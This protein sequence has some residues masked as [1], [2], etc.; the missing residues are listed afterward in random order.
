MVKGAAGAGFEGRF[1]FGFGFGAAAGFLASLTS[2]P[3]PQLE[4]PVNATSDKTN[5]VK[6][7]RA[8]VT[9]WRH[10]GAGVT[11]ED[12]LRFFI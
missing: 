5:A 7:R 2:S 9:S 6:A 1:G 10:D 12:F 3:E 11:V 4:A 8:G